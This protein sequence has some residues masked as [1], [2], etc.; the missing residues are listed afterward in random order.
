MADISS[1]VNGS[2]LKEETDEQRIAKLR[3]ERMKQE[4]TIKRAGK[5]LAHGLTSICE[6]INS[7]CD[8]KLEILENNAW[9]A[10]WIRV[11]YGKEYLENLKKY[12]YQA[13][14][15]CTLLAAGKTAPN[16]VIN[17]FYQIRTNTATDLN[18][19]FFSSRLEKVIA[20]LC[21]AA[22][23]TVKKAMD[24]I[25]TIDSKEEQLLKRQKETFEKKLKEKEDE[26][27][28][29]Q[30]DLDQQKNDMAKLKQE[31]GSTSS[32]CITQRQR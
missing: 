24:E 7:D 6:K 27:K 18:V 3:D 8:T 23:A 16:T 2:E 9:G 32:K 10:R 1:K 31:G 20:P 22:R 12:V 5:E 13:L 28:Q 19:W 30:K 14:E 25:K 11:W 21:S 17:L 4:E 29:L 15:E 26:V